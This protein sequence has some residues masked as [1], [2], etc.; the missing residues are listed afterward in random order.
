M[1]KR[2]RYPCEECNLVYQGYT[3]LDHHKKTCHQDR[4]EVELK[5]LQCG[6]FYVTNNVLR[7][8]VRMVHFKIKPHK[9]NICDGKAFSTRR[10]LA[11]HVNAVH[12]EIK[13]HKC[14]HCSYECSQESRLKNHIQSVHLK[15]RPFKCDKC[16]KSYVNRSTL[17]RHVKTIHEEESDAICATKI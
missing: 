16:Q 5:C 7:E 12:N 8:H 15:I 17:R 11:I 4:R 2:D 9:C 13:G 6:K 14:D 3:G 10:N 1:I